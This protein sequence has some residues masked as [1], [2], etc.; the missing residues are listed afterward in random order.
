MGGRPSKLYLSWAF[1]KRESSGGAEPGT[2]AASGAGLIDLDLGKSGN[3]PPFSVHFC[4][5]SAEDLH[6]RSRLRGRALMGGL[7]IRLVCI[8]PGGLRATG[9]AT[10]AQMPEKIPAGEGL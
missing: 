5:L 8:V 3:S 2:G 1:V 6:E 9:H 7:G 10:I 4:S